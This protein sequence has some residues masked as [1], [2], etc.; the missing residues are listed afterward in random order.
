MVVTMIIMKT[1]SQLSFTLTH[2]YFSCLLQQGL[3]LLTNAFVV[4]DDDGD[5]LCVMNLNQ[6]FYSYFTKC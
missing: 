6:G 2:K 3:F 1:L 5:F 4:D